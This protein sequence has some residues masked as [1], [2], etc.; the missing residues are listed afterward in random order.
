MPPHLHHHDTDLASSASSRA[1]CRLESLA[2]TANRA[3]PLGNREW[4]ADL[5][6]VWRTRTH[7]ALQRLHTRARSQLRAANR[8]R[9]SAFP[10]VRQHAID[11]SRSS[12]W[13]EHRAQAM[14]LPRAELVATCGKRWRKVRCACGPRE[15]PVGCGQVQLCE[16]CRRRAWRKWRR[17]LTRSIDAHVKAARSDWSRRTGRKGMLPGVY[18]VTLTVQHSGSIQTDREELGKAWRKLTKVAQREGWWSAYALVYEV[19]PGT[20]G[21]GHVHLHLAAVSSWIPYDRLH[22]VWRSVSGA[23]VLDV[24]APR[25][26]TRAAKAADYLS[27]YV[28]KGVEP[29]EFTGAKAGELLVALR[30]KRRVTTS[31]RFWEPIRDREACCPTC[32]EKARSMGAP[33]SL[34]VVAPGAVLQAMAERIGWWIPRGGIQCEL[35]GLKS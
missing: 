6:Y 33:E 25:A 10:A 23:R 19:T 5:E 15:L 31:L 24:K 14:A 21:D 17:R 29:S 28:T 4:F 11:L 7:E 16:R 34:R 3:P 22:E 35:K 32:G 13:A 1:T 26:S 9:R 8:A 12:E 27:K 2:T 18:L 30:G 20:R